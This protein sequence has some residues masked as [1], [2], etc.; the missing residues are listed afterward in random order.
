LA[1]QG[2]AELV[3]G[4]GDELA[5]LAKRGFALGAGGIE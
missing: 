1:S 5:L 3:R 2:G 4:I